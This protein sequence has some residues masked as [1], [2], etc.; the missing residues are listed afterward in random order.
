MLMSFTLYQCHIPQHDLILLIKSDTI[1]K[2]KVA[3]ITQALF[4]VPY[5]LAY[6]TSPNANCADIDLPSHNIPADLGLCSLLGVPS[7]A[8][9]NTLICLQF[10]SSAVSTS[11]MTSFLIRCQIISHQSCIAF[12]HLKVLNH[13]MVCYSGVEP[14]P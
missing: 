10:L 7:T 8:T 6:K 3:L 9:S 4:A 12:H 1:I 2:C 11:A 5:V 14:I 13:S